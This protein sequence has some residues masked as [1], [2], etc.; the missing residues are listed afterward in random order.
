MMI[1]TQV[2]RAAPTAAQAAVT[3]N[4]ASGLGFTRQPILDGLRGI[5][6]FLVLYHHFWQIT[7]YAPLDFLATTGSLG[8]SLFFFVSGHC[9][10]HAYSRN[11][12]VR[13]YIYRRFI[14]IVPSYLLCM[15]VILLVFGNPFPSRQETMWQLFAHVFFIHNWFPD[16]IGTINGVF[17][18][19][20]VEIQF[21]VLF[22]LLFRYFHRHPLFWTL[23]LTVFACCY[24]FYVLYYHPHNLDFLLNQLPGFI[25]LFAFGMLSSA[26][27]QQPNPAF[28]QKQAT[29]LAGFSLAGLLGLLYWAHTLRFEPGVSHWQAQYRELLALMFLM[30]TIS[31]CWAH[32][33]WHSLL[34]NPLLLFLS[35]ISYNLYL[36]HQ[37][38]GLELLSRKIPQPTLA[39][40]HIDLH[41]QLGFWCVAVLMSVGLSAILTFA[42]ERPLLELKAKSE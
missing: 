38:V 25:D 17:W 26:I 23:G 2:N 8:V 4:S 9:L 29:P 24:R 40:H 22:P 1:N 18:T 7:W 33:F 30:L 35:T 36:W 16:S 14:K 11:A 37:W 39:D 21:Y 34:A 12:S 6:I 5:A 27:L 28:S 19:L 32:Q 41:W 15:A 42:F 13:H 10:Y 3:I 31:S 20:G